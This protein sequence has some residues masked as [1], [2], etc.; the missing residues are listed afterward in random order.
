MSEVLAGSARRFGYT[1]DIVVLGIEKISEDSA[2]AALKE[3]GEILMK[4]GENALAF[5]PSKAKV[6]YFLGPRARSRDLP[7]IIIGPIDKAPSAEIRWLG[8]LWI[9]NKHFSV[10]SESGQVKE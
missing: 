9:K 10:T 7:S 6:I 8:V 4:A 3:V 5:E 1:D 2:A